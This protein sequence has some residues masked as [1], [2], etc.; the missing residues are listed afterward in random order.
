MATA[1]FT[2]EVDLNLIDAQ[3]KYISYNDVMEVVNR[4]LGWS[5]TTSNIVDIRFVRVW[6]FTGRGTGN[7]VVPPS[8]FVRRFAP[9]P[10]GLTLAGTLPSQ[11]TF[12]TPYKQFTDRGT[13]QR[14]AKI[15]FKGFRNIRVPDRRAT[16][17]P[18]NLFLEINGNGAADNPLRLYIQ[19]GIHCTS[20][21]LAYAFPSQT[22]K[23]PLPASVLS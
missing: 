18:N 20:R 14:P 15:G 9:P 16:D 17:D 6:L 23:T 1:A 3:N 19:I 5:A 13:F 7:N 10:F 8:L 21:M 2:W 22:R 11:I 4:Q 12:Q